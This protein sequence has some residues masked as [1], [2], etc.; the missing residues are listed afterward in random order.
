[1]V[2]DKVFGLQF[3]NAPTARDKK[4]FFLEVDRG[5][6]PATRQ[7]LRQTSYLRKVLSHVQTHSQ[8]LL[9]QHY[10]ISNVRLLTITTTANRARHLM[11][12]T[13]VEYPI[14]PL[15]L[16]FIDAA[17][18]YTTDVLRERWFTM[19]S[20]ACL[21]PHQDTGTKPRRTLALRTAVG[22]G[23]WLSWH[24][25]FVIGHFRPMVAF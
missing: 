15:M 17:S 1:M 18:L 2:P 20:R 12:S 13:I 6:M 24:H 3:R 16:L 8:G 22:A 5:T 9:P 25:Y 14:A 4:F 19:C 21:H 11:T 10:G 23:A 7:S